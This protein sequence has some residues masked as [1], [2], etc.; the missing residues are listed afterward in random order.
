M[1]S[2][3]TRRAVQVAGAATVAVIALAGCSA[4][5]TAETSE[6]K[7]AVSGLNAETSDGNLLVR[8]LQVAYNDPKG[9]PANGT[10]PIEVSLFNQSPNTITVTISSKPQQEVHA[11]IVSAQQVGLVDA[12]ASLNPLPSSSASPAAPQPAKFT[13]PAHGSKSFLPGA[14]PSLQ[15]VGLSDA[16]AAGGSL[17]LVFESSSGAKPL[18]VLA[19]VAVPLSPA[20]RASGVPNEGNEE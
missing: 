19:P 1:R 16:L 7:T 3:G 18:Q 11:G 20:P 9:Y 14:T 4:G 15:A 2:L 17:A 5:Q 8:D 6:L 13:I 12:V 10:A